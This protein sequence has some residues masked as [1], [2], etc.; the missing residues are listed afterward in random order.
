MKTEGQMPN[1]I[2]QLDARDKIIERLRKQVRDLNEFIDSVEN[3]TEDFDVVCDCQSIK[4]Y[5]D[6][7]CMTIK[8]RKDLN[9][10]RMY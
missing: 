10:M 5:H 6:E 3:H 1:I 4:G 9:K 7:D 8:F 2:R